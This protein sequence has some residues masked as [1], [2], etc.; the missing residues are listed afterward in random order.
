M[1]PLP[2]IVLAGERPGGGALARHFGV[3]ANALV[4]VAGE[5]SISR[6]IGVLRHSTAVAGGV[7]CGPDAGVVT[8]SGEFSRLLENGDYRWLAPQP[9]PAEST[10]AAL[11]AVARW[12]VLITTADHALLT[13]AIVDDFVNRALA[14][15]ADAVVGL[16]RYDAVRAAYP[17]SRRTVLKFADGGRCGTNLFLLRSAQG[18]RVVEFWRGLQAERKR[19]LRLARR[20]GIGTLLHYLAGRL[21]ASA[22]LAA[23]GARAGCRVAWVDVPEPR[24]AV[25][26]DSLA[27]HA[28]A[29]RVLAVSHVA[30]GQRP[31]AWNAVP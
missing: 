12:P 26:V 18:Q 7:I 10:L 23:I 29:E 16:A 15:Q 14:T 25:D 20:I 19:P 9:G 3:P 28:L 11:A 27:D 30:T 17:D 21:D 13:P 8:C 5:P 2:V 4:T 6:V 22:A 1:T 31:R 24:A